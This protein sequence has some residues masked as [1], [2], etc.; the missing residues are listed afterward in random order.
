MR[1]GVE[2]HEPDHT[3][4]GHLTF[5]LRYEGINLLILKKLFEEIDKT[6]IEAIVKAQPTGRYSRRIWFFYEWL[7]DEKLD[8]KDAK[9]GNYVEALDPDLQYPGPR[10]RSKRHRVWNNLPGNRNFCPLI[11]R[12]NKLESFSTE[13]LEKK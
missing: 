13:E 4:L 12:T 1:K 6:E 9:S 2:R 7:I 3:P 10:E 8:V 11:R 5:A